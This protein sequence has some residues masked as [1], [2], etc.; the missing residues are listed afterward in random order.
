MATSSD[1]N[2]DNYST[3]SLTI[4]D[5][6]D[7]FLNNQLNANSKYDKLVQEY[8]KLK[9]K[10]TIL[11]KAYIE[12]SESSSHKDQSIRKYEQE[13]EGLN[14]RNQQLTSRVE[15]LQREFESLKTSINS[16][17]AQTTS[18]KSQNNNLSSSTSN[19]DSSSTINASSSTP[20]SNNIVVTKTNQVYDVLTEELQRKITEN[21]QLHS[22]INELEK[23]LKLKTTHFEQLVN[24]LETEKSQLEKYLESTEINSKSLIEKLQ[25]DKIK[26]ELNLINFEEQINKLQ[27][28][29]NNNNF[30]QPNN[31]ISSSKSVK[32]NEEDFFIFI[33][34]QTEH[35]SKIYSYLSE[36][37]TLND[38]VSSSRAALNCEQLFSQKL[39]PLIKSRILGENFS[40]QNDFNQCLNEFFESNQNF[41]QLLLSD[42]S[43]QTTDELETINKKT[44]IYL[45]KLNN[46]VFAKSMDNN[47]FS[48]NLSQL[49][50]C[51]L[52]PTKN[53]S[54]LTINTKFNTDLN[55]LVDLLEKLLFVLNEKLSIQYSLN[56]S[57]NLNTIDECIV[58]YL[59][60][61]KQSLFQLSCL[62]RNTNGNNCGIIELINKSIRIDL[63]KSL[64]DDLNMNSSDNE[65]E[66]EN[67]KTIISSQDLELSQLKEK[68]QKDNNESDKLKFNLDQ[69]TTLL[70]Q[71]QDKEQHQQ[72]LIQTLNEEKE[73][74]LKLNINSSK[75]VLDIN[76]KTLENMKI[77]FYIKKVN[78]LNQQIDLLDSKVLFYYEELK[79]VNERLKLQTDLN[80]L[81]EIDLN[82]VR[83]QLER[84]RSSYELQMST[85]SDHLIEINEKMAKHSQENEK[86]KQTLLANSAQS[87]NLNNSKNNKTTKSK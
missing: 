47:N 67:L 77:D 60:Q 43:I 31:D 22:R 9:S 20:L 18:N 54:A 24:H 56:L 79:S 64:S 40:D 11:K 4:N 66:I 34:V 65:K 51:T 37:F 44:K 75:S 27:N 1:N 45:N 71:L 59:T 32:H 28:K 38:N 39:I 17:N 80:N 12:L 42:N 2:S 16:S 26:L 58:S 73:A 57:A 85:M 6:N 68:L 46:L 84:T 82:E 61:F 41:F 13:I 69:L 72:E 25:N 49:L 30:K 70:S 19:L 83:D 33:E 62:I 87:L 48:S 63:N 5:Q 14:F 76:E 3:N 74:Y 29:N 23:D 78:S 36:R 35:L 86:L 50:N 7:L 21:V 15:S 8:V 52:F 55:I 53:C 81:Q 10:L